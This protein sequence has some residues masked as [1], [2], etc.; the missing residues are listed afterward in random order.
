M[1]AS[2]H[3]PRTAGVSPSCASPPRSPAASS[4][5][6]A[7]ASP[8][9]SG[10]PTWRAER[11][12]RSFAPTR[13]AGSAF[14]QMVA[15]NQVLWA[16]DRLVFPWEKTGWL[17]LYAV[18]AAGGTPVALTQGAFEVEYVTL[19]PVRHDGGLQLERGRH[20][21][22]APLGGSREGR[23]GRSAHEGHGDRVVTRAR[24][25]RG[26]GVPAV[27]SHQARA[28]RG[29]GRRRSGRARDGARG[30]PRGVSRGRARGARGGD[31]RR[32]RREQGARPSSSS[33]AA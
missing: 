6:C 28:P 25:R 27:V 15:D 31:L 23:P 4:A 2:P 22:P 19:G 18:P 24:E 9:R 16:G 29:Q 33:P 5:R 17:H 11:D 32:H 8:G 13:A 1:T 10:S 21:P 30:H 14:H 7:R 12:A 20:R 26:D 3:S